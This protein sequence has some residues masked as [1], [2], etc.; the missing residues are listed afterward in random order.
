MVVTDFGIAKAMSATSGATLTSAGMAIGTPSYM[1]PEQ[2]AGEREIDGRSDLYSLG[3]VAYQM[4]S[5][6]LPFN[7]PTVAGILMKQITE[8]GAAAAREVSRR[9][10]G[11][12][13]GGGA[14]PGE[15]PGESL[16]VGRSACAARWRAGTSPATGRPGWAGRRRRAGTYA[17]ATVDRPRPSPTARQRGRPTD[18]PAVNAADPAGRRRRAP[19]CSSGAARRRITR[20]VRRPAL[21]SGKR[22][23]TGRRMRG[24]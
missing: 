2:A 11:P 20:R 4:L 5:G 15:G 16:A 23:A 17:G 21:P 12:V 3:I 13:A 10:G 1:S 7:A 9:A 6:E 14:L 18:R 8:T 22:D 19:A 24:T